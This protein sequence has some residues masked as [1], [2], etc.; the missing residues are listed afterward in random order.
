[1]MI[2]EQEVMLATPEGQLRYARGIVRGIEEF[3][4]E[5]GR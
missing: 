5:M 2:P 3:L 1:M 4:R